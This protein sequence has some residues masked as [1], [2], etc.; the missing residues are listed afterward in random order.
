MQQQVGCFCLT[1]CSVNL[2]P[3]ILFQSFLHLIHL[4]PLTVNINDEIVT[5]RHSKHCRPVFHKEIITRKDIKQDTLF[6]LSFIFYATVL[7]SNATGPSGMHLFWFLLNKMFCKDVKS[8]L[9]A[10]FMI[11]AHFRCIFII[12]DYSDVTSR[13]ID[14]PLNLTIG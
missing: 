11:N 5:F 6:C 1:L 9:L 12:V 2:E 3:S 14:L 10:L 7:F 8:F 4:K 13:L